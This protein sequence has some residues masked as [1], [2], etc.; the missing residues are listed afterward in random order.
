MHSETQSPGL[1]LSLRRFLDTGMGALHNRVELFAVEMREE[2]QNLLE[3]I[4]WVSLALFLGM[5]ATIVI[6]AT[7]ILMF[8]PEKRLMVAGG[9]CLLYFI[10]ALAAFTRAKARLKGNGLPFSETINEMKKDQ[11]CLQNTK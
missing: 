2:K 1:F 7:V 5:M 9:F 10:G 11:E 4:V 8:A 6:T 3:L